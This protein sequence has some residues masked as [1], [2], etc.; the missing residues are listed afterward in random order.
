MENGRKFEDLTGQRYGRLTVMGLFGKINGARK[1]NCRCDCGAERVVYGKSMRAGHTV[2][3]GCFNSENASMLGKQRVEDLIGHHYGRL[4]VMGFSEKVKND[5]KWNCQCECGNSV[6]VRAKGLKSGKTKS[7]GCLRKETSA[8][9]SISNVKHRVE[10]GMKFGRLLVIKMAENHSKDKRRTWDCRCDCGKECNVES[11][12]LVMGKTKSCGCIRSE[13]Q[14]EITTSQQW[15][16]IHVAKFHS[17]ETKKKMRLIAI[18]RISMQKFNGMPMIPCVGREEKG[19]LDELSEISPYP[20]RRQYKIDG[21]FLDGYVE[22]LKLAIEFDEK[23]H[24]RSEMK[25]KD[26]NRQ[27]EIERALGCKFF[28]VTSSDWEAKAKVLNEFREIVGSNEN[29]R[30]AI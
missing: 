25:I 27:E 21:Y 20:L 5:R 23:R 9:T 29:M 1:W 14:R 19:C 3:C 17:S 28:R 16:D 12:Q 22:E 13:R 30:V 8:T 24:N 18:E 26:K 7:C 15:R 6:S 11:H 4:T 10:A 2:S